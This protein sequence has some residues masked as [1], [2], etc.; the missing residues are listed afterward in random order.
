MTIPA[1][2]STQVLKPLER[3]RV[4]EIIRE[5]FP[6]L[7]VRR[8]SKPREGTS[9]YAYLVNGT[10]VFRFPKEQESADDLAREIALLKT[11]RSRTEVLLPDFEFLGEP[12]RLFPWRFG[13]YRRIVGVPLCPRSLAAAPTALREQVA[14]DV[15]R[16]LT[17]LHSFPLATAAESWRGCRI[18]A[19]QLVFDHCGVLETWQRRKVRRKL[20]DSASGSA[21]RSLRTAASLCVE[22]PEV[23]D[24]RPAVIHGDL[25]PGHL[26]FDPKRGRICGVIDFGNTRFADPALDVL[27]MVIYYGA[28]FAEKIL[29]HYNRSC[30]AGLTARVEVL[31][32]IHR[33]VQERGRTSAA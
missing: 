11:L 14:K 13:G 24:W 19:D 18:A 31:Y 6:S 20:I 15:G 2:I 26:L 8:I 12:C 4:T 29:E 9:N 17:T 5:Q 3:W 33:S 23:A 30:D 10:V 7:P 22:R 16:F 28:D 25:T 32:R 21:D 27:S 1:K